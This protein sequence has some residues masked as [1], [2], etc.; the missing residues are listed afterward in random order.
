LRSKIA[1]VAFEVRNP[2]LPW[3]T[4]EAIELLDAW[5][6]TTFRGFEWGSGRS[7][8][9]LARRIASLVSVEHNRSW[10]EKVSQQLASAGVGNVD[11]R[12]VPEHTYVDVIEEFPDEH[13]DLIV[14][15][16]LMRDN[17]LLRSLA[18]LRRGGWIVFDNANW[19]LRNSH[20]TPHSLPF[21]GP[22]ASPEFELA[23]HII[24]G[25]ST[26]WTT[27][28]VNETLILVKPEAMPSST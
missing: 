20:R 24:A 28:G 8:L 27:N 17:T 15:D 3:F 12:F 11:Y 14:V 19:Y 22:P 9:W 1:L 18:K 26:K 5:L 21:G 4:R 10:H 23:E 16:G 2:E 13:F 7:S 6:Q 25:W